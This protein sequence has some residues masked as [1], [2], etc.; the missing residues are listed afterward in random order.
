MITNEYDCGTGADLI[1]LCLILILSNNLEGFK[2]GRLR[3]HR[4]KGKRQPPRSLVHPI[5]PR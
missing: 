3:C 1:K 4:L 2:F 5:E